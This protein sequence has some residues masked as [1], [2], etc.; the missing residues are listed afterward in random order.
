[1]LKQNKG[2]D[3]HYRYSDLTSLWITQAILII[4]ILLRQDRS[5]KANLAVSTC[6]VSTNMQNFLY[7]AFQV[8]CEGK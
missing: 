8:K 2:S 6:Q 3:L 4:L 7:E 5:Y 1:M